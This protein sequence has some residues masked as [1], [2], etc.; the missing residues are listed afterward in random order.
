[1]EDKILESLV[2]M[3]ESIP[4]EDWRKAIDLVVRSLRKFLIFDNLV[5]YLTE[6]NDKPLEAVYARSLGRG[7]TAEAEAAWGENVVNQVLAT[8][9]VVLS[10]PKETIKDDRILSPY[11]LGL[12]INILQANGVL[13]IIRFGGPEFTNEQVQYAKLFSANLTNIFERRFFGESLIQLES[14]KYQTQLQ[15]DF[16]ATISHEFNTPLGFIKGYTTSL[17]RL[18]IAWDPSTIQE[19]LTI[20]DDETD[21]LIGLIG[22][23]LDSA[24]LKNGKLPINFQPIHLDSLVRDLTT[25]IC[26]R[27]KEIR[28]ELTSEKVPPIQGDSTRIVQVFENLIE[29][30]IKY[31]SGSPISIN[32]YNRIDH[33][34]VDFSDQGPGI[35]KEHIPYLFERFY[36]VPGQVEKR[37]T[38]LGLFICKEIMLAH[39]GSITV[40][41]ESELGT[42]FHIILPILQPGNYSQ[43]TG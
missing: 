17:L 13:I 43:V 33:L 20:I 12:P 31:A 26:S 29:N 6:T 2:N 39:H 4:N 1:M 24:R 3:V 42:I 32:I 37:G 9:K 19:F 34:E 30:A 25:R 35:P 27:N 16:I 22:H 38:G 36:R 7:R 41:S 8:K 10:N 21:H 40:D 18:D 5:I 14:I 23:L 15:D 28:I 11:L